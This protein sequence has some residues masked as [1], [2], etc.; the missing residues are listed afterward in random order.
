MMEADYFNIYN[1]G[2]EH[3]LETPHSGDQR[4]PLNP[5][6]FAMVMIHHRRDAFVVRVLTECFLGQLLM[7]L[8]SS[9][10]PE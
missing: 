2:G 8:P 1:F 4:R 9:A 3:F 10:I 6:R 7:S 5:H